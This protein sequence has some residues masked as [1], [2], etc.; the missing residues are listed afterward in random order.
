MIFRC[1][2]NGEHYDKEVS[3][4][5]VMNGVNLD[6]Q[7]LRLK[8]LF[9]DLECDYVVIDAGGAIGNEAVNCCGNITRDMIR[10]KRYPGWKTMNRVERFDMRITD[11]NAEP[12]LYPIQVSGAGASSLQY[13]MLVIAQLE[14]QRKHISL[15]IDEESAIPEL[16]KRLKYMALRTSPTA[17]DK[18]KADNMIVSFINTTKLIEEAIKTQIVKLPSGRYTYDEKGGRKDR[19]ISMIYGLWFINKLEEDLIVTSKRADVS[20]YMA[21]YNYSK[22]NSN[23]PFSDNLLRLGN[24]GRQR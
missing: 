17:S 18:D 22:K 19:V 10:N 7:I 9:Y 4:I 12:V 2:E 5:E 14:F 8:Q 21:S 13:N 1:F 15:L 11:P 20:Q 16:N 23:I 3:Y 6:Q 24:F